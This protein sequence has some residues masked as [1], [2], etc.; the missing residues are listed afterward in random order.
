[1]DDTLTND[2]SLVYRGGS[3]LAEYGAMPWEHFKVDPAGNMGDK[4]YIRVR[5]GYAEDKPLDYFLEALNAD[6]AEDF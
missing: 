1:M 3:L 4:V 5:N 6:G 2:L